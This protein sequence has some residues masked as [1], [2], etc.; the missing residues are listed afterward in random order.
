V[1]AAPS[2]NEQ[3]VAASART[4][5]KFLDQ[6]APFS[7]LTLDRV[8]Q[9]TASFAPRARKYYS[10]AFTIFIRVF[11]RPFDCFRLDHA[12]STSSRLLRSLF[13]IADGPQK[14]MTDFYPLISDAIAALDKK[15]GEGRSAFYDRA[16]AILADRLRKADP[17]LSESIIEQERQALEDAISKVEAD[18]T[19]SESKVEADATRSAE[20]SPISDGLRP[21]S[22]HTEDYIPEAIVEEAS[23]AEPVA[24]LRREQRLAFWGFLIL[25]A[26]WI[27]DLFYKP[28]MFS[29]WRDWLR[30]GGVILFPTMTILSYFI[31]QKKFS[32]EEEKRAYMIS[33]PLILVG[34]VLV[35]VALYWIFGRI[36]ATPS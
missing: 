11:S 4:L 24:N 13:V 20:T 12:C 16:R 22:D 14:G 25:A 10:T 21:Q 1:H 15:N 34:T 28:P 19:R 30:L 29:D 8:E 32:E 18:A 9:L 35:T 3:M 2:T 6:A 23:P 26:L 5:T 33:T 27:G 36:A 17:P 7:C 31:M